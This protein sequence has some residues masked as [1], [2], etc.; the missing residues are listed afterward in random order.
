VGLLILVLTSICTEGGI[1]PISKEL[2]N[3]LASKNVTANPSQVHISHMGDSQVLVQWVSASVDDP[4]QVNYGTSLSSLTNYANGSAISYS[5]EFYTSGGIHT[6]VLSNLNS[7]TRYYYQVGGPGQWSNTFYFSSAPPIGSNNLMFGVIGDVGADPN[8]QLTVSGLMN[9]RSN[10]G[11]DMVLHAGDLSY[12]SNYFPGGPVWDHYG[13]IMEPLVAYTFYDASVGNHES[14][15]DF[16]AF[17]LRYGTSILEK[18]SNGGD[19]YWS[20]DYGNVHIVM[21][22]SETDY[23]PTSAQ[24]TWLANDLSQVNRTILPW[25]IA[26]WHRPWYCSN[27]KHTG[28]GEQM[29]LSLE[30]LLNQYKVDIGFTGHVHAYERITEIYN[31]VITPGKTSYFVVGNGGTPEGLATDWNTQPAWSLYRV[32]QWGF[33]ALNV[34]NATHAYWKMFSDT[35]GSVMDLAWI[36]KPYPR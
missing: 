11:L 24:Y 2:M 21:L 18:N 7:S 15:D 8:S 9:L 30:T 32:A 16:T 33:G 20:V 22:S 3:I 23:S 4:S 35:D 34:V 1:P 26:M 5:Y 12:A 29:R 28:D 10:Y 13:E 31:W 27:Q 6:V 14:T 36:V 25:I 17:Q 19:F